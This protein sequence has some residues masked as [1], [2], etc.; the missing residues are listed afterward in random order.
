VPKSNSIIAATLTAF[1]IGQ[2]IFAQSPPQPI[3]ITNPVTGEPEPEYADGYKPITSMGVFGLSGPTAETLMFQADYLLKL[4]NYEGAITLIK[5]S[6]A[7]ND[8]D[9]DAH[10]LYAQALEKKLR[11]Q[12]NKDP[13]LF[14]KCVK[15]YLMVMR[16]EKGIEKGLY[17]HGFA[18]PYGASFGDEG[19]E[20]MAA[21]RLYKLTGF[22]PKRGQSDRKYLSLVLKPTTTEVT[23]T[24]LNHKAPEPKP[25]KLADEKSDDD[26]D[27]TPTKQKKPKKAQR[28]PVDELN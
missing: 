20:L 2:P 27:D 4:G 15:E 14:N 25:I 12:Q 18:T 7:E 13:K 9:A 8:D 10:S 21:Q 24:V 26:D 22:V 23:G 1:L 11:A 3:G 19:R 5:K 6:L 16:D 17:W 28:P